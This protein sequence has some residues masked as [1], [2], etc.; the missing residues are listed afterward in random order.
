MKQKQREKVDVSL[1]TIQLLIWRL[2]STEDNSSLNVDEMNRWIDTCLVKWPFW[3]L[4]V[5]SSFINGK[6]EAHQNNTCLNTHIITWNIDYH[7]FLEIWLLLFKIIWIFSWSLKWPKLHWMIPKMFVWKI[8]IARFAFQ[9]F[10]WPFL[11]LKVEVRIKLRFL[12]KF[13]KLEFLSS[14]P[15]QNHLSING[16]TIKICNKKVIITQ[17]AKNVS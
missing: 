12:F 5:Y 6:W 8:N 14:T 13:V 4:S 3:K 9:N 17:K 16:K 15:P 11:Q 1:L 7:T 10:Q 2:S